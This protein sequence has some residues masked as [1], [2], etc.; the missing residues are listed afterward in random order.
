MMDISASVTISDL[1]PIAVKLYGFI[2]NPQHK[3]DIQA[4]Q[5]Y[6]VKNVFNSVIKDL[7]SR[8]KKP[9]NIIKDA[10]GLRKKKDS[11]VEEQSNTKLENQQADPVN[12]LLQK[13]LE[14][15]F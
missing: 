15:L 14:K 4:L 9:E 11:N 12:K 7:K 13:G 5:T 2:N 3:L 1:P 6:L 10:L 8:E